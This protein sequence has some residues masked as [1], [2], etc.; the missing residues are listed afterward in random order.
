MYALIV[1]AE[2]PSHNIPRESGPNRI[3]GMTEKRDSAVATPESMADRRLSPA[4]CPLHRHAHGGAQ[5]PERRIAQHDVAAMGARDV[6]RDGEAEPR[7]ALVL[8][9]RIVEP[10]ERLEHFLALRERNAGSVV[11]DGDSQPAMIP[12]PA[13]ECA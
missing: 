6:A 2:R 7:A 13:I 9:A 10:K 4:K 5:A 8:I 12:V 3:I 1:W 11:V